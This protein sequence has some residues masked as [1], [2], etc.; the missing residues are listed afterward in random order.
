MTSALAQGLV[1]TP[2]DPDT[3]LPTGP[4]TMSPTYIVDPA[5][6]YDNGNGTWSLFFDVLVEPADGNPTWIDSYGL[7]YPADLGD[8]S[9]SS[10]LDGNM[11][12][13]IPNGGTSFIP[14][15]E[16]LFGPGVEPFAFPLRMYLFNDDFSL[17]EPFATIRFDPVPEPGTLALLVGGS[18]VGGL[19]V[20]RR[21]LVKK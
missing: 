15:L 9:F 4:A 6:A 14:L 18:L 13:E 2:L 5:N 3:G 19:F 1:F 21:R 17:E 7:T 16:I 10:T 12:Y 11:P 20:A 8:V